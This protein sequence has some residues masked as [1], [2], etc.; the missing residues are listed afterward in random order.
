MLAR[1]CQW[2]STPPTATLSLSVRG[3]DAA[4]PAALGIEPEPRQLALADPS[5]TWVAS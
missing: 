1:G 2:T 5:G 3:A 4:F